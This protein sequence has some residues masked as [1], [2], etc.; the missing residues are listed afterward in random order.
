MLMAELPPKTKIYPGQH[1]T[2]IY[3]GDLIPNEIFVQNLGVT[4][5]KFRLTSAPATP[6]GWIY[7]ETSPRNS[8]R[9]FIVHFPTAKFT[10]YNNGRTEIEVSG[11]GVRPA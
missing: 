10:V 4:E 7:Y 8:V 6:P 3:T 5:A 11:N 9:A 2:F 1:G